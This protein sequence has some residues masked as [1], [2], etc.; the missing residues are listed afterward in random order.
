MTEA[1]ATKP[2][3]DKRIP[4]ALAKVPILG[5]FCRRYMET[6][7]KISE[8]NKAVLADQNSEWNSHKILE[9]ARSF[10]RPTEKGVEPKTEIKEALESWEDLINKVALAR[11][12]VIELTAKELGIAPANMTERDPAQEGPLKEQRKIAVEIGN[13]LATMAQMTTDDNAKSA[14]NDF[15]AAN[16]LP[17]VG[18][19][20][21]RTFGGAATATPKYRVT[22]EVK[23]GDEILLSEK[24]F[25]K[26]AL[27][28]S[29]PVFGYERGKSPKSDDL[30]GAWEAAGN[31]PD[32]TKQNPVVFEDNGLTYTITKN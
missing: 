4:T 23:K 18:R 14:V 24:G 20:Q 5:D 17:S 27:A 3:V 30:R 6:F 22:I 29:K 12:S 28:L 26:T 32:E 9:K 15:L 31:T 16:P 19:D 21:V 11:K 13:H 25:T 10:A 2:A 7:D 8:Y 1:T